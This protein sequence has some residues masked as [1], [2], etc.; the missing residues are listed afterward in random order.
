VRL[1]TAAIVARPIGEEPAARVTVTHMPEQLP[2][3]GDIT[4]V[5]HA[6]GVWIFDGRL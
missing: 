6:D 3:S 1:V 4:S 5:E 2:L